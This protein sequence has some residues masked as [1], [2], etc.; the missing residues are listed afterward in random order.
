[1]LLVVNYHYIGESEFHYPGIH[2]LAPRVLRK[3]IEELARYFEFISEKDLLVALDGQ[4]SLP[5]KACLLTFDD[6]LREQ[7]TLAVPVLDD[8]GVPAIFFVPGQPYL[9]GKPLNVHRIHFLRSQIEPSAFQQ[10]LFSGCEKLGISKGITGGEIECEGKYFW[11]DAETRKAKYLLN[12]L[13]TD[14]EKEGLL[15]LLEKQ[16]GIE[17][18]DYFATLY[19]SPRQ[20]KELGQRFSVGT[21]GYSHTPLARKSRLEIEADIKRGVVALSPI[22]GSPASISYPHGYEGAISQEV[23]DAAKQCG[24]RLGFTTERS[25][26]LTL[27]APLALARVDTNDAPAGK[28]PIILPGKNGFKLQG[29]M[30]LGRARFWRET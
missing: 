28:Q 12:I 10:M 25:F 24:L 1:M 15:N 20:I 30:T 14:I 5:Q 21:H 7:H 6:G 4:R 26:N 16:A 27:E 13:L 19:M 23:F 17:G 2:P 22:C 9:E 3:Q 8:L 18:E 29:A 11:D